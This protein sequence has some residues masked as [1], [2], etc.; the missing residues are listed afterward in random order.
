[1][2]AQALA[3]ARSP[4]VR[5]TVR[6]LVDLRNLLAVLRFWRWRVTV[7]PALL[8]GGEIEPE[9]LARAWTGRDAGLLRHLAGRLGEVVLA[10]LEPRAA[11]R[12]LLGVLTRR[13]RR[14]GR[15]PL[16]AGVVIDYL[17]CCQ[18]AARNQ[19]LLQAAG[20]EGDLKA[21]ALP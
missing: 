10:D 1:M 6:F 2:L 5:M 12:E 17:W 3:E 11:E 18:V 7:A 13:L 16:E 9:A 21:A 20:G 19:A 15:A 14:A 8:A 4:A